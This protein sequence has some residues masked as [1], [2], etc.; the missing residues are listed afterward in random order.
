MIEWITKNKEWIFSGAGIF[1]LTIIGSFFMKWFHKN[2]EKNSERKPTLINEIVINNHS[3][4][5]SKIVGEKPVDYQIPVFKHGV[6]IK[7]M[8]LKLSPSIAIVSEN[9]NK[10]TVDK[11]IELLTHK[12]QVH[13]FIFSFPN[14]SAIIPINSIYFG[15]FSWDE[16][17]ITCNQLFQIP[18]DADLI[19]WKL[20][21]GMQS[22]YIEIYCSEH[23]LPNWTFNARNLVSVIRKLN[24]ILSLA[25][26]TLKLEIVNS[27]PIEMTIIKIR[28]IIERIDL[29]GESKGQN[30]PVVQLELAISYSHD[31]IKRLMPRV[32]NI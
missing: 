27:K 30:N 15:H 21:T 26:E 23:R 32:I 8:N 9:L 17:T 18:E 19:H 28:D 10:L 25:E 7:N 22:D 1:L 16:S 11:I 29:S 4:S 2:K 12:I 3:E 20:W 31:I 24:T 6:H 13:Y 14:P 5:Q